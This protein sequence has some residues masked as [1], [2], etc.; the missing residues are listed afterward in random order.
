MWARWRI[1]IHGGDDAVA[2]HRSGIDD[3]HFE[4][5]IQI[6]SGHIAHECDLL[7]GIKNLDLLPAGAV[8]TAMQGRVMPQGWPFTVPVT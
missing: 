1:A 3:I 4:I 6:D 7:A 5:Q 2:D 8:P